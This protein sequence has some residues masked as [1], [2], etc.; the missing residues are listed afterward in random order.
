MLA[1]CFFERRQ[2]RFSLRKLGFLRRNVQPRC[3]ARLEFLVQ[4]AEDALVDL[5][6]IAGCCNLVCERR[7]LNDSHDGVRRKR[8]IGRLQLV[9]LRVRHRHQRFDGAPVLAPHVRKEPDIHLRRVKREDLTLEARRRPF[10]CRQLLA[11]R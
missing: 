1:V 7:F 5:H 11:R 8:E 4:R 6:D 3:R 2:Q 10:R 9:V